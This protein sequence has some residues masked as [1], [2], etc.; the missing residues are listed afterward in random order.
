MSRI[1]SYQSALEVV[2]SYAAVG[3]RSHDLTQ[4]WRGR[5]WLAAARRDDGEKYQ[6]TGF[7]D[8]APPT[9]LIEEMLGRKGAK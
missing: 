3:L 4:R 6:V 7:L 8:P 1:S 5:G 9:K 2:K